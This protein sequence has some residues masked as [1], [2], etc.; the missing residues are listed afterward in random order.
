MLDYFWYLRSGKCSWLRICA[1][2]A[3]WQK[4]SPPFER[5]FVVDEMGAAPP[6]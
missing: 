1:I 2:G 5:G 3:I 6:D 4:N